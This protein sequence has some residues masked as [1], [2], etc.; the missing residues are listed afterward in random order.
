MPHSVKLLSPL[1][2]YQQD[3]AS[4]T[5]QPDEAQLAAVNELQRIYDELV[6]RYQSS[7][8][9]KGLKRL[10]LAKK[11]QQPVDGLYLWGGV[12]REIGRAHV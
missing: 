6:L 3:L 7:Q 1:A 12:G 11:L 5:F 8:T 2:R 4:G 10:R 9:T